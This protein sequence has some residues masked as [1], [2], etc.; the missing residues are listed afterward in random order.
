MI[1]MRLLVFYIISIFLISCSSDKEELFSMESIREDIS[2]SD[3]NFH[4]EAKNIVLDIQEG[5][6]FFFVKISHSEKI[7]TISL[8][9]LQIL[10]EENFS[11]DENYTEFLYQVLNFK[12]SIPKNLIDNPN[13]IHTLNNKIMT[14]YTEKGI[15]SIKKEYTTEEK[16]DNFCLDTILESDEILTIM[17]LFYLNKY[18]CYH[19]DYVPKYRFKQVKDFG[20]YK[21]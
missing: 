3:E 17:Y 15:E 18:E 2:N 12:K 7:A 16:K 14:K 11:Q 19:D 6:E 21:K 1:M 13:K 10:Y 4:K 8:E 5:K 20:I 9:D